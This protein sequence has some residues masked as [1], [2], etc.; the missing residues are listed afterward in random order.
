MAYWAYWSNGVYGSNGPNGD[1][2]IYGSIGLLSWGR[3]EGFLN[4]FCFGFSHDLSQF[5]Q[6]CFSDAF[7]AFEGFQQSLFG[8]W[9]DTWNRVEFGAEL[10]LATLVAM[11]CDGVAVYL[12]LYLGKQSEQGAVLLERDGHR[13]VSVE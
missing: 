9:T 13:R 7:Y 12:V 5:F 11:E 6:R 4:A 8:L 2:G 1:Y 10:A 3:G